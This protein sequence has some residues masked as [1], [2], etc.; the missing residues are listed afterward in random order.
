M[1]SINSTGHLPSRQLCGE[2]SVRQQEDGRLSDSS[3][4]G[5]PHLDTPTEHLQA[6][7]SWRAT[8]NR[9]SWNRASWNSRTSWGATR[10]E[11]NCCPCCPC[12]PVGEECPE[13]TPECLM[14]FS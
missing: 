2:I 11:D 3:F 13:F 8:Y 9:A 6:S 7:S 12:C 14:F 5:P 4:A 1:G 10:R